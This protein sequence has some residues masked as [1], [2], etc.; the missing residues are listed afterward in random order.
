MKSFLKKIPD[1]LKRRWYIVA[2]LAVVGGFILYRQL[3]SSA[4]AKTNPYK[5]KIE[6]LKDELTFSGEVD[7]DEKVNLQFQTAGRLAWVGVKEGEYVQKWQ[8]IASLDQ[9]QLKKTMQRYLNTYVKTRLTFDEQQADYS[10]GGGLSTEAQRSLQ[11]LAEEA[12]M[13]LN[14]SVIDVELQNI[15]VEY[16]NLY[17]PIEGVVD[18]IDTP[19]AGVNISLT[20]AQTFRVVNPTTIFFLADADQVDV[21]RLHEGQEGEIS[22]DPYPD[23]TVPTKI[24]SIDFSPK[25]GETG[26]VYGVK[27]AFSGAEG[28]SDYKY[29]LGMTGDV[30]FL[31]REIPDVIAVPSA[32]IKTENGKQY[33]LKDRNGKAVKTF[34]KTGETIDNQTIVSEGLEEGDIIY[35]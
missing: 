26:T 3:T 34:I 19:V 12:Q 20:S 4:G 15:T 9:R 31:L 23:T 10:S 21:V 33:V 25:E 35:D 22:F 13:D 32:Y 11:R 28:N 7:A 27:M 18:H 24:T 1:F 5:V 17:T 29:R 6:T 30:S 14:N 16:A 8:A 2:I